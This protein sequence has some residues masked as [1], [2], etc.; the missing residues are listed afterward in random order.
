MRGQ[1][2]QAPDGEGTESFDE[3]LGELLL[4]GDQIGVRGRS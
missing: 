2:Y 4:E 3:C 1:G